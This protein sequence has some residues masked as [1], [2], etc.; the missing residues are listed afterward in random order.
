MHY[1]YL[2][3]GVGGGFGGHEEEF[4]KVT[5]FLKSGLDMRSG[6]KSSVYTWPLVVKPSD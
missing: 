1:V 3:S 5:S 6:K 2:L 4:E